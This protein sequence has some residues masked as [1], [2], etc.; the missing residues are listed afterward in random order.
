MTYGWRFGGH[1]ISQACSRLACS[2][3]RRRNPPHPIPIPPFRPTTPC[4]P[5]LQRDH[6]RKIRR[7][8]HYGRRCQDRRGAYDGPARL[9]LSLFLIVAHF[10]AI[11]RFGPKF[12]ATSLVNFSK[13]TQNRRFW[14]G[15]GTGFS[16]DLVHFRGKRPPGLNTSAT[17]RARPTH[18][19]LLAP[20]ARQSRSQH[21]QR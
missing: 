1:T 14:E 12:C 4:T 21:V 16:H 15:N 8:R 19:T 17:I 5:R 9:V 20:G 18:G 13:A 7:A 10:E 11:S 3:M 6:Q 2:R